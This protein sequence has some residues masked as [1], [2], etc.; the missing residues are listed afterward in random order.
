MT[1]NQDVALAFGAQQVELDIGLAGGAVALDDDQAVLDFV[2]GRQKPAME[3]WHPIAEFFAGAVE[4]ALIVSPAARMC[5]RATGVL[6]FT[7]LRRVAAATKDG[8]AAQIFAARAVS[9][10]RSLL[11]VKG[12]VGFGAS[13]QRHPEHGHG[14]MLCTVRSV[15][16]Q[17][18]MMKA[19]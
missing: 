19:G 2:R 9:P 6:W 17:C 12:K 15:R 5:L 10:H 8:S 1:D 18:V 16:R 3:A 4:D 11:P 7:G 13:A 14:K